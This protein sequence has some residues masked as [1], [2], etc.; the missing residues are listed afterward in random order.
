MCAV[1]THRPVSGP[2]EPSPKKG[3]TGEGKEGPSRPTRR[4]PTPSLVGSPF[5]CTNCGSPSGTS[6]STTACTCGTPATRAD[7]CLCTTHPARPSSPFS[8]KPFRLFAPT[9]T[10]HLD[11]GYTPLTDGGSRTVLVFG[12][13]HRPVSSGPSRTSGEWHTGRRSGYRC[14]EESPEARGTN[15]TWFPQRTTPH[16]VRPS[17]QNNHYW[18]RPSNETT[19]LSRP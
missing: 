1:K 10:V 3:T 16:R 6:S 14:V 17:T 4:L 2:R 8:G 7:S 13:P 11:T 5:R 12:P 9:Q 19:D 15:L 18:R